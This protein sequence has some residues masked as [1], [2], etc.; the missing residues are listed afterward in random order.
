[1]EKL[2]LV[3]KHYILFT[4]FFSLN[5]GN[6]NKKQEKQEKHQKQIKFCQV[7]Q[8]L[9]LTLQFENNIK[10]GKNRHHF[11]QMNMNTFSTLKTAPSGDYWHVMFL[12]TA[13]TG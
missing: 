13:L 7:L 4:E 8:E 9:L 2:H 10:L 5:A 11:L 3:K 12:L 1:M 6:R